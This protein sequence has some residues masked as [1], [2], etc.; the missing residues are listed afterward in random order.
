[1]SPMSVRVFDYHAWLFSAPGELCGWYRLVFDCESSQFRQSRRVWPSRQWT[2][3]AGTCQISKGEN[4]RHDRIPNLS[5]RLT[6]CCVYQVLLS[7][8][9]CAV[10]VHINLNLNNCSPQT[11]PRYCSVCLKWGT[12][13]TFY[14]LNGNLTLRTSPFFVLFSPVTLLRPSIYPKRS[15]FLKVIMESRRRFCYQEKRDKR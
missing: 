14:W 2:H 9:F 11:L 13:I 10:S 15:G 12:N 3:C 8:S 6:S 5:P 4:H 1:M 7:L